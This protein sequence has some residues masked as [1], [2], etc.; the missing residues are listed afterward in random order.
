MIVWVDDRLFQQGAHDVDRIA[1]LRGASIR[2]HTLVISSYPGDAQRDRRS[3]GF[4]RWQAGLPERLQKEVKLL[5]ERLDLVSGNAVARGAER[6]LVSGYTPLHNV[7]GCWVT[8]SEA[9]R[10]VTLPT[11][12]LVENA[13]N[14]RAFL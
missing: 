2:R 7:A 1:L 10:A 3:P 6:L 14:D 8:I 11:Y 12:V 9:V 13:I 5:R 4:D